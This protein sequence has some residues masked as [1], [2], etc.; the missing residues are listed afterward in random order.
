MGRIGLFGGTFDPP[1]LGHLILA[2]VTAD[3]LAL[4]AVWFVPAG[5]P[6]HKQRRAITPIAHRL[7]MVR[8]ALASN[9]LFHLSRLDVDRPGP[10]FTADMVALAQAQ[11]PTAELFF[12]MGGDSLGDLPHWHEPERLLR[13]CRL[14]VFRRPEPL[15]DMDRLET[16]LPGVRECVTFVEGPSIGLSGTMIGARVRAGQSI[17]YLVPDAVGEYIAVHGLYRGD[18]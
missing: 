15:I 11:Q 10:H 16:A 4:D 2:S 18:G 5:E 8:L 12:L 7:E 6:P 3:A 1:H 13:L 14:A 9:P 17:R